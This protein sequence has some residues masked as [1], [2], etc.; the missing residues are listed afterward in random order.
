MRPIHAGMCRFDDL[1]N[2]TLTLEGVLLMNAYLDNL[3]Y[4]REILERKRWRA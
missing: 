2:G 4:N 3:A 1:T